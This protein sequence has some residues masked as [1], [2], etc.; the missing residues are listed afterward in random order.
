MSE[1][2][3]F[4]MTLELMMGMGYKLD[5]PAGWNDKEV[6]LAL[7]FEDGKLKFCEAY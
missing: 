2:D 5:L 1:L 6:H 7:D 4:A 3:Y